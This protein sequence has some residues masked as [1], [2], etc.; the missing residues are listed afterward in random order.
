ML[1]FW[2]NTMWKRFFS[3]VLNILGEEP[4][5]SWLGCFKPRVSSFPFFA[6]RSSVRSGLPAYLG[7]NLSSSLDQIKLDTGESCLLVACCTF[8]QF[9]VKFVVIPLLIFVQ[10]SSLHETLHFCSWHPQIHIRAR[11]G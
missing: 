10:L 9:S 1:Q 6:F 11:A 3:V 5:K 2:M 4:E 7:M 8:V